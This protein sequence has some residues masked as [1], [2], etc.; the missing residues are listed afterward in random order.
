MLRMEH[1]WRLKPFSMAKAKITKAQETWSSPRFVRLRQYLEDKVLSVY[2]QQVG[3]DKAGGA[4][5]AGEAEPPA[6]PPQQE[7]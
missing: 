2:R 4:A 1:N 6:K 3:A 7:G 5:P